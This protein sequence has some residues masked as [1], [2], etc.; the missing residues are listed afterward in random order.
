[1]YDGLLHRLHETIAEL[2]VVD[3]E[4]LTAAELDAVVVGLHRTRHRLAAAG[5]GLAAHC[6]DHAGGAAAGSG[7]CRRVWA[8][9]AT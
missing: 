9:T 2:T 4:T 8:C 3:A 7:T 1:M 6:A 5:A